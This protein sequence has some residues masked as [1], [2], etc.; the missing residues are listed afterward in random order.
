MGSLHESSIVK[1]ELRRALI[2]L[3]LNCIA[4][5]S[6]TI[7]SGILVG[8]DLVANNLIVGSL[9]MYTAIIA[10]G[11]LWSIYTGWQIYLLAKVSAK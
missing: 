1:L 11:W 9:Q 7:L 4:P 6:G 3:I 8:G 2:V 10:V 5:G